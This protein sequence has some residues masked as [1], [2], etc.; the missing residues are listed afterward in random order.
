LAH[1]WLLLSERSACRDRL[2][3]RYFQKTFQLLLIAQQRF[4]CAAYFRVAAAGLAQEFL[5]LAHITSQ[6]G[7][8]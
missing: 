8:V 4:D 6:R 3:C 7:A 1:L 5:P 2:Q